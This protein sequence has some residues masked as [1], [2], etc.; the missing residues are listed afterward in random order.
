MAASAEANRRTSQPESASSTLQTIVDLVRRIMRADVT[1]VVSFSL[2]DKTITWRVASGFRAHVIDKDQPLVRPITNPIALRAITNGAV[3]ILE[4]I[5]AREDFPAVDFPVHVAEGVHDLACAP[6]VA[7]GEPLGALLA[8]YRSRHHFADDE[9]L[10][11]Q[12]LATM[13]ALAL[14]NMRL[15]ERTQSGERI[16]EQ[17]FDAIG[18]GILVHDQQMQV[19]RCNVRAAEM[20]E[21]RPADV[22][23]LSFSEVFARLF[24]KRAAAYYLAEGR[25]TSS[26]FEVETEEGRRY[27]VSMFPLEQ[28]EGDSVSVVTWAD[29]TKFLEMQEQL[30]RSRR[31]ASVGEL[32]AGVAH[33]INN[34]LAAITTCAEATMRNIREHTETQ[35]LAEAHQWSYYLEEIVRQ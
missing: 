29:V 19:V 4:G 17:T 14:D 22:I 32:A 33:E 1:S 31:L 5:G 10:L 20:M 25:R 8:G 3:M 26:V 9:K 23:G 7:R 13:A 35:A 2:S 21:M 34:P 12:D 24:G 15:L 18:E 27:L 6:L 16:W 30:S 11:L 28:A